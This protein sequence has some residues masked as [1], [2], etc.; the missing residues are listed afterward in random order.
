MI[1]NW[2]K[3]LRMFILLR[4][5]YKLSDY[6]RGLFFGKNIFIR[7]NSLT[8]GNHVYLGSHCHLSVNKLFIGD[9]T[10]L[11]SYV[12]VVGGDHKF[13]VIGIPMRECGRDDEKV[14]KIGRDVW[15]GHGT[16]ILHGVTV[17]DGAIIGAGSV[18]LKDVAPC[19]VVAG[20]PAKFVRMRFNDEGDGERHLEKLK[21]LR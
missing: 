11:A 19:S 9:F 18:V 3:S 4:F 7:K 8:V 21:V 17:G 5:K 12:S 15:V 14:V 10:M 1:K 20:C 2:A 16:I 13:D 6:G